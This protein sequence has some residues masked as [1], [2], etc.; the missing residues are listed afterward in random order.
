MQAQD[1]LDQILHVRYSVAARLKSSVSAAASSPIA[2]QPIARNVK[3]VFA[4]FDDTT[5]E[6]PV[7]LLLHDTIAELGASALVTMGFKAGDLVKAG[8]A[9]QLPAQ[10]SSA[11]SHR[12]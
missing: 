1:E 11:R 7:A 9:R 10:P 4:A 3:V 2:G 6:L 12:T 8:A 5:N